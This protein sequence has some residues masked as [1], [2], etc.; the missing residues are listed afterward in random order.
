MLDEVLTKL[1]VMSTVFVYFLDSFHPSSLFLCIALRPQKTSRT[2]NKNVS[3][4]V[5]CVSRI[6]Q[7]VSIP[8]NGHLTVV[9]EARERLGSVR[10]N[11]KECE[12][13]KNLRVPRV[14]DGLFFS[15][16]LVLWC[17]EVL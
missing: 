10:R 2:K 3:G 15:F 9:R 6:F 5:C 11:A 13:K 7:Q 14:L 1:F 17:F 4:A 8:Q 16:F 12:K